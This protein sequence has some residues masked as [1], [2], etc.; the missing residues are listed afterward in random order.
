MHSPVPD[1]MIDDLDRHL[2]EAG[3]LDR[4]ALPL[5]MFLAWC[6][7]LQLVSGAFLEAHQGVLVRLRYRDL[8]PAEFLT[9]ATNGSIDPADLNS[10]GQAFASA[11]Y[12]RYLDDFRSVFGPDIYE[13]K[14]DWAHY[15]Q[16][17]AV[18]TRHFMTWKGLT[19][20]KREKLFAG[21]GGERKWW[22]RWRS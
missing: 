3:S 1:G 19:E 4:A 9:S 11:Y 15:D 21:E 6:G 18:L 5:G 10:E 13:I 16:I 20:R 2:P 12:P 7:N 22:H 14:D 8:S 17:A